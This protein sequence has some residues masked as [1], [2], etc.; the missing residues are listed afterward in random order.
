MR[1]AALVQVPLPTIVSKDFGAP[2]GLCVELADAQTGAASS[3][4]FERKWTKAT[5]KLDCNT[6]TGSFE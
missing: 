6:F 4:V 1:N 5:V 2:L 3:G